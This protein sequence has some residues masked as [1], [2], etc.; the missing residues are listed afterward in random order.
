M[1]KHFDIAMAARRREQLKS[2]MAS[3]GNAK[4]AKHIGCSVNTLKSAAGGFTVHRGTAAMIEN[5]LDKNVGK[6]AT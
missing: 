1:A 5:W 2:A 4:V 6:A 3:L